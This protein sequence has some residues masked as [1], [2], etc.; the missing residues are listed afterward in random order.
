MAV[1]ALPCQVQ[2][3]IQALSEHSPHLHE[4]QDQLWPL[5]AHRLDCP[6]HDD[7]QLQPDPIHELQIIHELQT[8]PQACLYCK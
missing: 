1:S 7:E 2:V 4:V 6:A 3:A 8:W 5:P